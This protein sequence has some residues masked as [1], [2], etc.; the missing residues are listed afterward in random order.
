MQ[1][2]GESSLLVAVADGC[3]DIFDARTLDILHIIQKDIIGVSY[4][5]RVCD[6]ETSMSFVVFHPIR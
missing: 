5:Q 6:F 2:I 3:C 4:D 1:V